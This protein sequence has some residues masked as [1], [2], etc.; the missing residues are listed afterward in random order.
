MRRFEFRLQS[1]LDWR[2]RRL[3]LEK[4]KLQALFGQWRALGAALERLETEQAEAERC[5]F[6]SADA[7]EL[8]AL[9]PFRAHQGRERAR[10]AARRTECEREIA[11]QRERVLA[12][13]R[14]VRLLERL[15]ARREADWRAEAAKEVETL[16][17]ESYLARWNAERS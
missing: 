13:E 15:K 16:A 11:E 2:T 7:Q 4:S 10:I 6:A 1:V 8:A 17:A 12:S 3:D 14:D 9:D 5:A